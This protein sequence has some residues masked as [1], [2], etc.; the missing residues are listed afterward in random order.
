MIW[1]HDLLPTFLQSE[2]LYLLRREFSSFTFSAIFLYLLLFLPSYLMCPIYFT[3][4]FPLPSF[5]W[6]GPGAPFWRQSGGVVNG[7]GQEPDC[8]DLNPGS[9]LTLSSLCDLGQVI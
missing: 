3:L 2:S 4:L 6:F 9:A 1:A 8:L 5:C 7:S